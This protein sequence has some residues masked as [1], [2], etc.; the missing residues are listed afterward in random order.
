MT[1]LVVR[2]HPS[3]AASDRERR[4]LSYTVLRLVLDERGPAIVDV[5]D[6][7]HDFPAEA[8]FVS[9]VTVQEGARTTYSADYLVVGDPTRRILLRTIGELGENPWAASEVE[10]FCDAANL[11]FSTAKFISQD[12]CMNSY[13]NFYKVRPIKS[14]KGSCMKT[15]IVL[16]V[17][18]LVAAGLCAA[19]AAEQRGFTTGDTMP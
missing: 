17:T 2:P 6:R 14:E 3:A 13:P 18:P 8:G 1:D 12:E 9:L 11:W 10:R 19:L 16:A 7:R 4:S 5:D 15:A